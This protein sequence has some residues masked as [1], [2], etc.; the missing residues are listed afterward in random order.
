MNWFPIAKIFLHAL[1]PENAHNLTLKALQKNWVPVEPVR[2]YDSL[3]TTLW[4]LNFPNPVGLAAG[5]DKNA[6]VIDPV[7]Q[8][9]FG[10][11]EV[12]SVTPLPQPGNEQPRLFRLPADRAVINRMG[13]NN[14]GA[15]VFCANLEN[16]KSQLVVGAN[17]G[18]NKISTDAI[19]DYLSLLKRV[20]PVANYIAVNI[21]SPNTEGLR[22]LQEKKLL[23][24]LIQ[25]LLQ[26]RDALEGQYNSRKPIIIKIAPDNSPEQFQD[27]AELAMQ[28]NVDGLIVNNTTVARPASLM[29]VSRFE[30]G[31]LSGPPMFA[32]ST[33]T[34]RTMYRLT[35]GSIPLIGCGGISSGA[36]AYAKIKAGA[37]LVQLYTGLVYEGFG[38][39]Q[40]IKDDLAELL[41]RDGFI[42]ISEAVGVEAK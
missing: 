3:N 41:Q 28:Y 9:G 38:L 1:A 10:F 34:L 16:R 29:S 5:F 19:A 24:E 18:R 35:K 32:L 17:I 2:E 33:E 37:S 40:K 21:S 36:D 23:E 42:N 12:G 20:Y 13:M 4:N 39:V 22:K 14:K 25:N 26:M 6:E 8:H 31:G 11:I 30:T 27:I 15:D 7:S